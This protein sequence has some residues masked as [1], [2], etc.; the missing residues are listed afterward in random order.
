M[1]HVTHLEAAI[2]G[3][4]LP[5]QQVQTLHAGRPLWVRYDLGAIAA[6]VDRDI[7]ATRDPTLWRY[8]ELLP[9]E[10]DENIV[11]L[12]EGL[13]PLLRCERL[14]AEL[15]L[16]DLW[17]KNLNGYPR[18]LRTFCGGLLSIYKSYDPSASR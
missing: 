3:T 10:A 18:R 11:S 1:V 14:G 16:N 13:T 17:V 12:G 6:S 9:V 4:V 15:G 7:F 5:H 2:D 8:R